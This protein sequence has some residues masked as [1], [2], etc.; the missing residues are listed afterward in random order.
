MILILDPNLEP[1]STPYAELMEHLA[2]LPNIEA[3][4]HHVQGGPGRSCDGDRVAQSVDAPLER[5]LHVNV[6]RRV[7][8]RAQTE[9]PFELVGAGARRVGGSEADRDRPRL[10]ARLEAWLR[11][12]RANMPRPR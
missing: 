8:R 4:V 11:V 6:D 5:R 9:Q 2:N 12:V 3:R 1:G 7:V 10:E